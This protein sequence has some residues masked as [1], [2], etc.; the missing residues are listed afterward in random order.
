MTASRAN[1]SDPPPW[2]TIFVAEIDPSL[3]FS[4]VEYTDG[5]L[6]IL[7]NGTAISPSPWSGAELTNCVNAFQKVARLA[8]A[9]HG[10][11]QN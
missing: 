3:V 5:Q 11:T 1:A 6:D 9:A 10:Q 2:K 4:M 8:A 7:R